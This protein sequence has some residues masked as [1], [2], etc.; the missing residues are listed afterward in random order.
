MQGNR[1][2]GAHGN[3]IALAAV[4]YRHMTDE[5]QT[6]EQQ[7]RLVLDC[8]PGLVAY[9]DSELRYRFANR[10]YAEWFGKRPGDLLGL[11]IRELLGAD[12][13]ADVRDR[14]EQALAGHRLTFERRFLYHD[15]EREVKA[16]YVPDIASGGAVRGLVIQVEDITAR[17]KAERALRDSEEQFR[18]L[19]ANTPDIISRFDREYRFVYISPAVEPILGIPQAFHIGRRHADVGVPEEL[20][21]TLEGVLED[22][23]VTGE[24]RTASFRMPDRT[25]QIRHYEGLGIPERAPDGSVQTVLTIVRDNTAEFQAAERLRASESRFRTMVET[26]SEGIF[27]IDS[28]GITS[29][30][31][32]RMCELLGCDPGELAGRSFFDFLF[33]EEQERGQRE[34]AASK[35]GSHL[36][37]EYR[38]RRKDGRQIWVQF[39][40]APMYDEDG[41]FTGMLGMCTDVT[42][43]VERDALLRASEERYRSLVTATSSIVWTAS[44]NGEMLGDT[45]AWSA[46]TGKPIPAG[47]RPWRAFLHPDDVPA[48]RVA[49]R[50]AQ[51]STHVLEHT[52][53][54]WNHAAQQYRWCVTR[55]VPLRNPDGAVREWVGTTTDIHDRREAEARYEALVTASRDG[56]LIIDDEGRQVDVNPSFCAM[57]KSSR[58]E[59]SGQPLAPYIPPERSSEAEKALFQLRRDGRFSGEFPLRAADGSVVEVEWQC[60]ANFVPGLHCCIARDITERR[61]FEQQLQ[62]TQKVESLGV[63]AGGIAHD[64]NNLLVG[65]MGN[66]SLAMETLPPGSP[67]QPLLSDVLKASERA[68]QLTRQLLAYAGK[69]RLTTEPVDLSKLVEELAG[70]LS[71]SIPRQARLVL[72]LAAEPMVVEADQTQ[73]QQVVM[74]L[75]INAA[76]S[77][78]ED[79]PGLVTVTTFRRAIGAND[80]R[81]AVFPLPDTGRDYVVCRVKD[82]GS[83]M[84]PAVRERIFDPFFSTKFQGRGLGLSAVLG[85]IRSHQGGMTLRSSPGKGTVFQV[86][87]PSTDLAPA[88]SVPA[89][90]AAAAGHCGTVLVVDDEETVRSFLSRLLEHAGFDSL[91]ASNGLEALRMLA[92]NPA[93]R[94]I[95]LDLAMPVMTGDQA[96]PGLRRLNTKVPIILSSGYPEKEALAQFAHT[97]ITAFL[98][99]PYTSAALLRKLD[100]VLTGKRRS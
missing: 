97:G 18:T 11:S 31:N 64:F 25:G 79:Q 72:Q 45:T 68:A 41:V 23:F 50:N 66:T 94:A 87:L 39:T 44:P 69:T 71:A 88:R 8:V 28:R 46:Y 91:L 10:A 33:P 29:F 38:A 30:S 65:M 83:G 14:L 74:N 77:I 55:S 48:A 85:I 67:S 32:A 40:S 20:A 43:R 89:E 4:K 80:R 76:E 58:D 9:V 63:L 26:A 2:S 47:G 3:A 56:V 93:V 86:M 78:P 90:A 36:P 12:H 24:R 53:R 98:Q 62:Q 70:L 95:I 54:I 37:A 16:T 61:R 6:V 34:M 92:E 19:L 22:I 5:I 57:L 42:E 59:L 7:L 81:F 15:A 13:F 99:K 17:V 100:E 49:W 51:S 21:S 96:A 1:I 52:A 27:I 84:S 82:T 75:V 73:L 60:V 35:P